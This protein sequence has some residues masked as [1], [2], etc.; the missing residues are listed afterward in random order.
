MVKYSESGGIV[1]DD[2]INRE[3]LITVENYYDVNQTLQE[4]YSM[5]PATEEQQKMVQS[6]VRKLY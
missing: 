6:Y 1:K 3:R 2:V 4:L 5:Y